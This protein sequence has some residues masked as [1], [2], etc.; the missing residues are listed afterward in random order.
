MERLIEAQAANSPI[1]IKMD[2]ADTEPVILTLF[3]DAQGYLWVANSAGSSDQAEGV[4]RTYDQFD[5]E[6]HFIKQIAIPCEGD[7]T[8]DGLIFAGENRMLW[9]T[10]YVN[11]LQGAMRGAGVATPVSEDDDE[12]PMMIVC[13]SF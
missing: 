6:G 2:F 9:I 7:G 10:G 3:V 4:M 1:E 12:D 13:Y 5:P 8:K 11:A